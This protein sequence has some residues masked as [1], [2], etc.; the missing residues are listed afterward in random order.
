MARQGRQRQPHRPTS[1]PCWRSVAL[2]MFLVAGSSSASSPVSPSS[3]LLSSVRRNRL[4]TASEN[5]SGFPTSS[6]TQDTFYKIPT[7][8]T[9]FDIVGGTRVTSRDEFPFYAVP[10]GSGQVCGASLIHSGTCV[11]NITK[12]VLGNSSLTFVE[13]IILCLIYGNR[14]TPIGCPLQRHLC[15]RSNS[16]AGGDQPCLVRKPTGAKLRFVRVRASRSH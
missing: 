12:I 13:Y 11:Y 9:T 2:L 6:P 4:A 15:W 1:C 8:D 10:L 3:L 16:R 5:S 7:N 14:Y